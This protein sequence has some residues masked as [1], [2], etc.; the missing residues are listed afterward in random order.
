MS[1][2][3]IVLWIIAVALVTALLYFIGLKKFQNEPKKVSENLLHAC[4]YKVVKYLKKNEYADKE[5]IE[6][7]I[8]DTSIRI[9]FNKK[10][11]VSEPEK[12]SQ[13]VIE[14]LLD[15][16]YIKKAD[17]GKYTLRK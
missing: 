17:N 6:E 2:L 8:K 10:M 3:E 1:L 4:G 7:I 16:R 14:F 11:F 5:K 15:Q 13:N 9:G 12:L